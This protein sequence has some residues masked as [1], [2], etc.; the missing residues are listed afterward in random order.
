MIA[1]LVLVS[2]AVGI[3]AISVMA[4]MS[5][6]IWVVLL[7]YPAICSL[8]LLSAASVW[9]IRGGQS[10]RAARLASIERHA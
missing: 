5:M 2:A 10:G 9:S 8:T 4:A 3:I 7:A 1:G 6:P